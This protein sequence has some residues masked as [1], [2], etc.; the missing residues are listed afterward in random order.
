MTELMELEE[1]INEYKSRILLI[2][3]TDDSNGS[4][5]DS[6]IDDSANNHSESSVKSKIGKY[7]I[8]K[9]L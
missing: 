9:V 2:F 4:E 1:K 6:D 8:C 7:I 5:Q 3:E